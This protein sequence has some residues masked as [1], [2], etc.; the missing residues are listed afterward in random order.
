VLTEAPVVIGNV[1]ASTVQ[2]AQANMGKPYP[3]GGDYAHASVVTCTLGAVNRENGLK[4]VRPETTV[5]VNG[6]SDSWRR[7]DFVN[8]DLHG[9]GHYV[10]LRVDSQ[11]VPYGTTNMEVT[12]VAKRMAPDKA[13]GMSLMY[14]STKGYK[15]AGQWNNIPADDKWH[16]L[17]WKL[18]D[19]NFVGQWGF[20]FR[21]E[22]TGSPN[23]FYVKEVRVKK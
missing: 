13:A 5:V 6:L 11:F 7:L 10:Y 4:Q 17:T 22:A 14:E 23:E 21:I 9:E 18:T 3:W 8:P 1:P 20:N 15:N 16:D 19:A 12:I 2:L